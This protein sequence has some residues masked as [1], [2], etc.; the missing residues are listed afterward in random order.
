MTNPVIQTSFSGGELSPSLYG[1]VDLAKYHTGVALARN[2][3]VDYRGGLSTRTGTKFVGQVKDSS[4]AN[5]LIPFQFSTVQTYTLVFGNFTMRV[6]MNGGYVTEPSTAISG[7]TQATP[8]V[9]TDTAH[10]YSTG[11]LVYLSG[12]AGMTQLNGRFGTVVAIDANHYSLLDMYGVALSTASMSAY[13]SGGTAARVF[14]LTTPYA[15]ADLELL[16]FTQ[17]ADTMTLT[18]PSYAPMQL[19]RSNHWVWTIAAAT[20]VPTTPV[21][22]SI[23]VSSSGAGSTVYNY[24]VTALSNNGITESLSSTVGSVTGVTL[25][26]TAGAKNTVSWVGNPGDTLYNIY[27]QP[28]NQGAAPAQGALF[29]Y[30]GSV[31]PAAL[32]TFVDNNIAPDFTRCPPQAN[33]PFAQ[34]AIQSVPVSG[35]GT[36]YTGTTTLKVTDPSG[37]GAVLLPIIVGG[38][39]TAVS[40][41]YGGQGYTAP[42]VTV[43]VAGGGSGASFGTPVLSPTNNPFCSTYYQQRQVFGGQSVQPQG[44]VFSKTGDY[45]NL[46]Y[47]TPSRADDAIEATIASQTVNAIKHMIPL[48]SLIV[49]TGS[50]AWRVDGGTQSDSVSPTALLAVPQAYNGCSDVPPLVINYDILYVQAKGAIVRDL[51]YNFY[52]NVYTG[53]DI[54]MLS[55]HLFFGHQIMEWCWAEEPFKT[56]WAVREDGILLSL[57]YLKEQEIYGWCRHDTQGLYKSICSISEGNENAVYVIVERF[58]QGQYLQYIERFA[59]RN[60]G[61]DPALGIPADVTKAWCVD[62]GL[63]YTPVYPAATLTPTEMTNIP[64]VG[65]VT[66]VAGGSGYSSSPTVS[67]SDATGSG[68]T[69]QAVVSGGVITAINVLTA[70]SNYTNPQITVTDTT[71]SGAIAVAKVAYPVPM[72][73]SAAVFSSGNIGSIVRI[74]GGFGTITSVP[75]STQAIVNVSNPLTNI[76]PAAAGSWSMTVPVTT[77]TGLDHL[78]GQT[79]SILADGNVQPQQVVSNGAVTLLVPSTAVTVG[80]PF[81]AQVQSLYLDVQDQGTIQSKRKNISA[82]TVRTQDTRGLKAGPNF[83]TLREFKERTTQLMGQPTPLLTGD[84]RVIV[85]S[86]YTVQGQICIQQ[87]QPLPASILALIPEIQVGDS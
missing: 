20:F 12:I 32:N 8:G 56:V 66:V 86:V 1:R 26:T 16:K 21:P 28:E 35:G 48:N 70:G 10:G 14:T 87:D 44:L 25:S 83:N 2:F 27:R 64:V 36:L 74:N 24:V 40:V 46:T 75:S 58:V 50:G 39:I 19:T 3:Y 52:V 81:V 5:R 9:I 68:A 22:T 23:A 42:V 73:A 17:S 55:N 57:T 30:V 34:G 69:F 18:H 4:T 45:H 41:I 53:T 51:S 59:S 63:Q 78:N 67:V 13:T 37:S 47:S 62:C 76:W 31:S 65:S 49:L 60:M 80:L 84:Y 38:V 29:G 15:A 43:N 6:V 61:G 79:V 72:N 85:D 11:Q 82:L 7:I 54:S 77:V 71:G 33:N